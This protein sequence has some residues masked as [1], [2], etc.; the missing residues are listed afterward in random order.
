MILT[1]N[2]QVSVVSSRLDGLFREITSDW[3]VREISSHWPH[4]WV[5]AHHW[6]GNIVHTRLD[7]NLGLDSRSH[8]H[9]SE[10]RVHATKCLWR[11]RSEIVANWGK[12]TGGLRCLILFSFHFIEWILFFCIH[13]NSDVG[14]TDEESGYFRLLC[15]GC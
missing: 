10:S 3:L 7:Q 4:L 5:E 8:W 13:E 12:S 6:F 11:R 9:W 1:K 14:T 15:I 2:T